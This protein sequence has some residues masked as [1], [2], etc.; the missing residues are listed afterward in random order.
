MLYNQYQ[1]GE[2]I[3]LAGLKNHLRIVDN[4]HD[5]ELAILLKNATIYAQ[6]YLNTALVQCGVI[7]ECPQADTTFKLFLDYRRNYRVTDFNGN[8]LAHEVKG[9]KLTILAEAQPVRIT[10]ECVPFF[11]DERYAT[12]VYQIAAANYDGQPEQIA[13]ILR[14]YPVML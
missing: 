7:Q 3:T 1:Q 6:E 12:M 2:K 14:N 4:A 5:A 10:Y 8:E 9:N 11:N 13:Q